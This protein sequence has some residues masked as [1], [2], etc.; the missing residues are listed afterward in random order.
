M[1]LADIERDL[2]D[3]DGGL[4]EHLQTQTGLYMPRER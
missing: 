4:L 1:V 2:A 3:R